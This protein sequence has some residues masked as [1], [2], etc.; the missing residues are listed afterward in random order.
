[1]LAD[2]AAF[3]ANAEREAATQESLSISWLLEQVKRHQLTPENEYI[4]WRMVR[5]DVWSFI[6]SQY[7]LWQPQADRYY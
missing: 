4:N 3:L 5:S 1:V 7:K 2:F 6:P